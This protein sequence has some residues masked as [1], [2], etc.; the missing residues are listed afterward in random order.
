MIHNFG[1]IRPGVMAGFGLSGE[2]TDAHLRTLERA[3]VGA[4][5]SLG[6]NAVDLVEE[7][8]GPIILRRCIEDAS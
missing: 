6:R 8:D 4:V 3:G 5:V 1:W 2:L 7:D